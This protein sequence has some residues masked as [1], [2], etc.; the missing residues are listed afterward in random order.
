MATNAT[1][2]YTAETLYIS[3]RG[4]VVDVDF[5]SMS[6]TESVDTVDSSA[7][8]S[9]ARTHIQTLN[10]AEFTIEYLEQL[11]TAGSAIRAALRLGADGTLIYA[12]E[13]T[14]VGKPRYS[15]IAT[16]TGVDRSYPYDEIVS[17]SANLLRNGNWIAHYEQLNSV[18]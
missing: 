4:V 5:R 10:N 11:T 3:Y 1:N 6:V 2:R 7:G 12:P 13:G 16:V 14:A 9:R 15:C 17:V 8:V 18:F